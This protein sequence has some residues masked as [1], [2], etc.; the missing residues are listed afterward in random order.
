MNRYLNQLTT[1]FTEEVRGKGPFTLF[2]VL[3]YVWFLIHAISLFFSQSVLWGTE[4]IFYRHGYADSVIENFFF[5]L[6][7]ESGR[8]TY[9]YV[10]H[11]VCALLSVVSFHPV[12]YTSKNSW[13]LAKLNIG[14]AGVRL[15]TWC[16]GLMLFYAAIEAFDSGLLLM[17]LMAFYCSFAFV[18]TNNPYLKAITNAARIAC[19][20]QVCVVYFTAALYKL[21]GTQWLDGSALYYTLHIT[22]YSSSWWQQ[23]AENNYFITQLFTWGGLAYQLLF[24]VLVWLGRIRK[25]LLVIGVLFHLFIGA[26]FGLWFFALAMVICY[27]PFWLRQIR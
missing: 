19:I 8:S 4:K 27:V 14:A 12:F 7:Y 5:Q 18:H 11:I 23:F 22:H 2:G 25:P 6:V 17:L 3:V 1:Y 26:V 16:S 21:G 9:I 20:I 24:P 13:S 10:L 15:V